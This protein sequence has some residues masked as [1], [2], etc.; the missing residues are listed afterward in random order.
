MEEKNKSLVSFQKKGYLH[1]MNCIAEIRHGRRQRE[2]YLLMLTYSFSG[3]EKP[4]I[5]A[6]ISLFPQGCSHVVFFPCR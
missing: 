2:G 1:F 3:A 5:M 4:G 6:G